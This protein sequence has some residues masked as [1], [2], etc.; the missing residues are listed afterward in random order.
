MFIDLL[1]C[2]VIYFLNDSHGD[3]STKLYGLAVLQQNRKHGLGKS[4]THRE[5]AFGR[6]RR[7]H[8]YLTD[9]T[10]LAKSAKSDLAK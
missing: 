8:A 1:I 10:G 4:K 3:S 6:L 9:L 5:Q 2:F 7:Q